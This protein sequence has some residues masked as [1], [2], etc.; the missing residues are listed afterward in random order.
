MLAIVAAG[1][2]YPSQAGVTKADVEPLPAPQPAH[3]VRVMHVTA[4][5]SSPDETD[6]TPF[7][8]AS[9]TSVHDGVVA[10]NE[11]PMGTKIQIPAIYGNKIF[12]VED[13][14]HVRMK[15]KVDIWMPS[16]EQALHFGIKKTKIVVLD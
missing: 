10:T 9:G 1:S 3:E 12:V 6:D 2:L 15:N 7:I 5:S 13:R 11:L 4:Y 16:K 14:M 8:T